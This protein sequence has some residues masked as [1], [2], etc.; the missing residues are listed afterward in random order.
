MRDVRHPW[1]RFIPS[2]VIVGL[3]RLGPIGRIKFAPGTW[4]SVAG[5]FFVVLAFWHRNPVTHLLFATILAYLAIQICGEAEDRLGK[6]DPG[7]IVLDEFVAIPFC[8]FGLDPFLMDAG[9]SWWVL[10]LGFALFRVFDILKPFGI[11]KIQD[12]PGGIGCVADDIAA[13]LAV[14]VILN[15]GLRWAF[16]W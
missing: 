4:G 9:F 11:K 8:F 7:E 12:L 3:A 16:V 10:L 14:M 13:A 1:I 6:R 2:G 5:V 15:I